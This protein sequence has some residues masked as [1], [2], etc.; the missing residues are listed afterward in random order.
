M[1]ETAVKAMK[2]VIHLKESCDQMLSAIAENRRGMI[3]RA[4]QSLDEAITEVELKVY[5]A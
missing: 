1:D 2:A 3:E 5:N 4:K